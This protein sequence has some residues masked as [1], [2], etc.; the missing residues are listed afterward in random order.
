MSAKSWGT[1]K[2]GTAGRQWPRTTNWGML[3]SLHATHTAISKITQLLTLSSYKV[4]TCLYFRACK[5]LYPPKQFVHPA[6]LQKEVTRRELSSTPNS[7]L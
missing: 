3:Y 7:T 5:F 4:D 2:T 6:I 1:T